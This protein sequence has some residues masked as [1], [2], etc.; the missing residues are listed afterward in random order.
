VLN[1]N[2]FVLLIKE[3]NIKMLAQLLS[4]SKFKGHIS[5]GGF[6]T[7]KFLFLFMGGEKH[8]SCNLMLMT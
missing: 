5:F 4:S 3:K 6:W 7:P 8:Q 2:F 1:T